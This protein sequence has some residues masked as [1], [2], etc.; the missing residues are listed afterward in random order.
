MDAQHKKEEEGRCRCYQ[1]DLPYEKKHNKNRI[2]IMNQFK[3][4]N[5]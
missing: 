4:D 1:K 2:N 3:L 5:Y